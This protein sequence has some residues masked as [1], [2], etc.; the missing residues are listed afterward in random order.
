M[1][2]ILIDSFSS[3]PAR[4]TLE[5][6]LSHLSPSACEASAAAALKKRWP[7]VSDIS[8]DGSTRSLSQESP[9]KAE[10]HGQGRALPAPGSPHALFGFDCEIDPRDGRV[11]GTRISG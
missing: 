6:D 5:P 10:L 3:S 11:L 7:R 9:A 1:I 4:G 8:F 2:S